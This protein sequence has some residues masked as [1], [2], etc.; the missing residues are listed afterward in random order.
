[1]TVFV[2]SP[3]LGQEP[4]PGP[5]SAVRVVSS[6]P[7]VLWNAECHQLGVTCAGI[8]ERQV[9]VREYQVENPVGAAVFTTGGVGT[10]A[11][12][13]R[14]PEPVR[15]METLLHAGYEVFEVTWQDE[16]GWAAGVNS[17]GYKRAMCGFA[18]VIEWIAATRADHPSVMCAEGNS[19]GSF[20]IAYGLSVYGL[21]DLLDMVI[22]T[23]GP[24]VSRVDVACFGTDDPALQDAVWPD[25]MARTWAG[26]LTDGLMG[27]VGSGDYCKSGSGPEDALG[28]LQ[29]TSLVSPTEPRDY[30][31]P[32]TKVNF[33]NSE[34]DGTRSNHQG[35]IYYEQITSPKAWHEIAGTAH[36]IPGTAEGARISRDLYLKECRA[37]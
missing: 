25:Q 20:Q 35:R 16:S 2:A 3:V 34:G 36:G 8:P 21:E 37:W 28:A 27:W 30:T 32:Q 13:A 11:Y 31:F 7:C 5:A 4:E 26:S 14:G 12:S 10:G 22:L 29:A 6:E 23:G 15:T 19:G 18:Q 24:P 17:G 1:M 9:E 33:V